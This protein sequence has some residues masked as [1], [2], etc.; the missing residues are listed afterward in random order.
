MSRTVRALLVLLR[1][2]LWE[3][4]PDDLNAFPISADEW[5]EVYQEARRQTVV[6]LV[7]RGIRY[8]SEE[9]L[10]PQRLMF[11]WIVDIDRIEQRNASMNRHLL[12]LT[13]LL[14]EKGISPIVQKGQGVA[15]WYEQPLLRECGDIDLYFPKEEDRKKAEEWLLEQGH[16]L[17]RKADGSSTY[18]WRQIE[19][20]HHPALFDLQRPG[21]QAC[22]QNWIAEKGFEIRKIGVEGEIRIPAPELNLLLLNVHILKHALGRGIGLRQFCDLA[23]AYHVLGKQVNGEEIRYMYEQAGIRK[24]SGLLHAFL[25]EVLGLPTERLP[26][27]EEKAVSVKPLMDIV[28]QGGNFG[29][30]GKY[31]SI[32]GQSVFARKWNTCRAFGKNVRFSL[33]YAPGEAFHTFRQLLMGQFK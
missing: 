12:E 20:E 17:E 32:E 8:L 33:R 28:W 14:E 6:G 23:R 26:Y 21:V 16:G 27:V 2:G 19:V 18:R 22:L 13:C 5:E 4:Q 3:K 9:M 29:K 1:A 11:R 25:V 31:G 7:Y 10:P 24:W 15:A 30:Y